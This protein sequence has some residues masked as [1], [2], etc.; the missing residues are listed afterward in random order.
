MFFIAVDLGTTNIKGAIYNKKMELLAMAGK[1]VVYQRQNEF[2]E[3]DAVIYFKEIMLLISECMRKTNYN[4]RHSEIYL[5]LTGQAESFV[6]V[7]SSG[8]PLCPAVSWMDMRSKEE[9]REMLRDFDEENGFQ[10]TGQPWITPTW[11]ATKLRWFYKNNPAILAKTWKVL[12][13]KDYILFCLTGKTVSESSIRGFSYLF[14]INKREHWQEMVKYCGIQNDQMPE[15]IEPC[16]RI[17][18]VLPQIKKILPEAGDY[19]VNVGTLDH[20]A[21]MLGSNAYFPGTAAESAGTVLSLSILSDTW[22]FDPQKKIACLIGPEAGRYI[23]FDCC[24][25]GGVCMEWIKNEFLSEITYGRL[26]RLLQKVNINTAPTFLP[27]LTGINPPEYYPDA[28]GAFLGLSLG[29]SKIDMA[30]SVMEGVACMLHN[31]LKYCEEAGI[32]VERIVSSGGGANSK[33]WNQIKANICK[34]LLLVPKEKNASAFGAAMI[35]AV[36]AG[37]FHDLPEACK[38][39]ADFSDT[40]F[41]EVNEQTTYERRFKQYENYKNLL[42]PSFYAGKE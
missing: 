33:V 40:Y 9:C 17:G 20:I 13:L 11:T 35:G 26:E 14:D 7:D 2:V 3:F 29:H 18:S 28:R 15:V 21:G 16:K 36:D 27:Y 39:C 37:I 8:V 42:A 32:A 41:P 31:N 12:L 4:F 6:L 5:T 10:I 38:A 23:L 22:N 19:I 1:K 30:Y 34:K 25:S 24:D